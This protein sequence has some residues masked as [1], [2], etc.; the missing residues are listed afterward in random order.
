MEVRY[1]RHD[2]RDDYLA[3]YG[4]LGMKWGVRRYQNKDGTLTSAG[5]RREKAERKAESGQERILGA[6]K[7]NAISKIYG[8]GVGEYNRAKLSPAEAVSKY[9]HYNTE[10]GLKKEEPK[11]SDFYKKS[12]YD[13]SDPQEKVTPAASEKKQTE[14]AESKSEKTVKIVGKGKD[15]GKDKDA[16]IDDIKDEGEQKRVRDLKEKTN[17]LNTETDYLKAKSNYDTASSDSEKSKTK[18]NTNDIIQLANAV[19]N[20]SNDLNASYKVVEN[21][22]V[23][24]KASKKAHAALKTASMM[25]DDEIKT[26]VSRINLE[27]SYASAVSN[28]YSKF[29]APS[30]LQKLFAGV[31]AGAAILAT[32]AT[33][34]Q[35]VQQFKD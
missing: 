28:R 11:Q 19:K 5:K 24:S 17:I 30:N 21:L 6:T 22:R 12:H 35:L 8:V 34:Y 27:D 1:I 15:K 33:I 29:A 13:N 18:K 4:I 32:G 26:A 7:R 31:G 14:T 16:W 23:S 3:H 9:A 10:E 2:T 25:S 20:N